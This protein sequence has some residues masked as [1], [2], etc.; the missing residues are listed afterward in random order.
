MEIEKSMKS[1]LSIASVVLAA[2]LSSRM[3]NKNKLLE[4]LNGSPVLHHV[5][6]AIEDSNIVE[7]IVVLGHESEKVES[8]LKG[9][10][11]KSVY[12]ALYMS[13]IG[14]SIKAGVESVS[15]TMDGVVIILGDMPGLT[16]EILDSLMGNFDPE[17]GKEICVPTYKNQAGNPVLW[18]KRFFPELCNLKGDIGGRLL[19]ND[20]TECIVQCPVHLD[21]IHQDIDTQEQLLLM[22]DSSQRSLRIG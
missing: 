21:T 2:G 17:K 14:S 11:L 13:G 12:N 4:N 9:Y 8:T 3:E 5:L 10:E 20:F 1:L 15:D 6:N 18:S 22:Q 19:L 16:P 7:T